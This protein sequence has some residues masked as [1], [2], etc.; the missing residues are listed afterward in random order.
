MPFA[1]IDD[2]LDMYY[3]IDDFT[4]PWKKP[5]TVVLHHG[6]AKNSRMW[7]AWVPV[8]ARKYKVVR[9]DARGFGQSSVPPPGYKFSLS[10]FARDIKLL[11]DY[12]DLD[13]V[14][15]IGETVGG[16]ISMQF[17][18]EYPERLRSL[19]VCSSPFRFLDSFYAESG[20]RVARDGV[21]PWARESMVRRLDASQ[22]DPGFIEWYADQMGR[23]SQRVVVAAFEALVG[24]D[25]SENLRRIKTPTL[26]LSA[27]NRA[28][29]PDG[30]LQEMQKLIPGS[31][32]VVFKGVT[33][34]VHHSHP[35]KCLAVVLPFLEKHGD[36][37]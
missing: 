29:Y 9:L 26:L 31:E 28:G 22:V 36:P 34:F 8:L 23:T 5:E 12:L 2:D 27:E 16:S 18:S 15:L 33:G 32:A 7:Y 17:A 37:G 21:Y 20:R 24:N 13:K 3:D 35:E 10:G 14:H 25:L 4:D 30:Y 6:N 19:T 11:L 1:K